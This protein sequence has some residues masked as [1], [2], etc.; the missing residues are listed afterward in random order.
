MD[1]IQQVI[2]ELEDELIN[3]RRDFH[4]HPEL[5][6]EEVRTSG[7]V[8]SYL[9]DLGIPT[10]RV[11]RTGVVGLIEG[12]SQT[13]VLMLR[14]D[15]DALPVQEENEIPYQSRTPGVM[16]ACAHDAHTAILLIADCT[17]CH[18]SRITGM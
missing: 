11:T 12:K 5:G 18:C 9:Q 14:A 6:F 4:A 15:M 8:E 1:S 7:I 13:P 16:H 3:L 17:G 2:Q 10:R